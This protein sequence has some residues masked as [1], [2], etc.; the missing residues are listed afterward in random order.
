MRKDEFQWLKDDMER[1][2]QEEPSLLYRD[3]ILDGR[4]RYRACL[5]LK[6][7]PKTRVYEGDDPEGYVLSVNL[8]RRHLNQSQLAMVAAKRATQK[9][10]GGRSKAQKCAL[11]R[12]TLAKKCNVSERMLDK[13]AALLKAVETGTAI[14]ELPEVVLLGD[15]RLSQAEQI[16]KLPLDEQRKILAGTRDG[17]RPKDGARRSSERWTNQF[18]AMAARMER[19]AE[20]QPRLV[21]HADRAGVLMPEL[22]RRLIGACRTTAK[23]FEK[24]ADRLASKSGVR[25]EVRPSRGKATAGVST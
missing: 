19:L 12:A 15:M 8:Q 20:Q 4:N 21:D 1:C 23:A 7:E 3:Q 2:G 5:E 13:A 14:Q 16:A 24:G 25:E 18:E 6:I 17:I 9:W 11:S 10:G 22:S